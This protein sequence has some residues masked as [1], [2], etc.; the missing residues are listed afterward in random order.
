MKSS[1][2]KNNVILLL[3]YAISAVLSFQIVSGTGLNI[4]VKLFLTILLPIISAV[5]YLAYIYEEELGVNVFVIVLATGICAILSGAA[6]ILFTDVTDLVAQYVI[7]S[8]FT[9]LVTAQ[10][11]NQVSIKEVPEVENEVEKKIFTPKMTSEHIREALLTTWGIRC[12]DVSLSDLK[13]SLISEGLRWFIEGI[14][15]NWED[16]C[17]LEIYQLTEGAEEKTLRDIA[18][19][20]VVLLRNEGQEIISKGSALQF[21]RE[22]FERRKCP[23]VIFKTRHGKQI[24]MHNVIYCAQTN[25]LVIYVL[26]EPQVA[27]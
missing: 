25:H 6:K 9:I 17:I 26:T 15:L 8:G 12:T 21:Q 18:K 16:E 7:L 2:N 14:E 1:F 5:V 19:F 22:V 10:F 3:I 27:K 11:A 24:S 20:Y 23:G 13:Y 4:A